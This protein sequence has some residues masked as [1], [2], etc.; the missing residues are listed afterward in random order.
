ML[1]EFNAFH[2]IAPTDELLLMR[3]L[4]IPTHGSSAEVI[5]ELQGKLTEAKLA[6]QR[7]EKENAFHKRAAERLEAQLSEKGKT[8]TT[9][10]RENAG[11]MNMLHN[12][13]ESHEQSRLLA[14]KRIAL[15]SM[16]N[17]ETNSVE[18]TQGVKNA[19]SGSYV[20]R[21]RAKRF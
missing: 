16:R 10:E 17:N 14:E 8:I 15:A 20:E 5:L 9:L 19:Y 11:L 13:R 3:E 6:T 18:A 21:V 1:R 4:K 12:E 7:A 2:N